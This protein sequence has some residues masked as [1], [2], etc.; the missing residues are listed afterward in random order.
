MKARAWLLV[1]GLSVGSASAQPVRPPVP[2]KAPAAPPQTEPAKPWSAN[3]SPSEQEIALSI[4]R[5]GN[6]EFEESRYAQALAKYREAIPHWD[7]PAIRFNMVV[8]L[9][10]LDQPLEAYEDLELALKYGSDPLGAD[11]HAQGLTYRKLLLGQL[12][13]LE[14][15]SREPGAEV[16]LDGARLFTGAGNVTRLVRPGNHQIVVTKPGFLTE[17]IPLVLVPGKVTVAPVRMVPLKEATKLTRRWASWK[18]WALVG[19]GTAVAIIGVP[20]EL[21]AS[22]NYQAYDKEF[23]TTCPTGCGGDGQPTVPASLTSLE[24]TARAENIAAISLFT[25][26]GATIVAGIAGVILNQPRAVARHER[27]LR[28]VPVVGPGTAS[29]VLRGRF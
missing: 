27:D 11:V 7:H 22:S 19:V 2:A 17:T 29:V 26:G 8:C 5:A 1:V 20:F 10:N 6:A 14:V 24:R 23:G 25:V 15:V 16:S 13:K 21:Q 18:P 9:I 28:V 4:Y 3:V 12:A